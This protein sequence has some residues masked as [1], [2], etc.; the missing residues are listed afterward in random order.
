[1]TIEVAAPATTA[2]ASV[3][4]DR[5]DA[6]SFPPFP[7]DWWSEADGSSP[8]GRRLAF[9]GPDFG[10]LRD[11]VMDGI[12]A[13]LAPLDGWSPIGPI[14][15]PLSHAPDPALLPSDEFAAQGAF[16]PIALLDADPDSPDYGARIPFTLQV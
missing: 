1:R 5:D 15:L 16:S 9:S 2:T 8:T 6:Q 3:P 14:V 7:D 10:D 4:Y 12:A 11:V 13:S